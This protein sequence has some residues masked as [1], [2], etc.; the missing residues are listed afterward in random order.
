[1]TGFVCAVLLLAAAVR[2]LWMRLRARRA[3]IAAERDEMER[4]LRRTG[5]AFQELLGDE[6]PA[7]DRSERE[8]HGMTA[9]ELVDVNERFESIVAGLDIVTLDCLTQADMT[10]LSMM[11][12]S[13]WGDE[14]ELIL[15]SGI[16]LK[17]ADV[18]RLIAEMRSQT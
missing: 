4:L 8:V 11:S 1:M 12:G 3:R 14:A 13:I 16:A 17:G 18:R 6:P 10:V 5:V 9:P 2:W 15:P 7:W